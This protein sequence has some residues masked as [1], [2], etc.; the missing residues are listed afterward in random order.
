MGLQLMSSVQWLSTVQN[1]IAAGVDT[2][3]EFGP[4]RT[5]S[6]L[7]KK[8]DKSVKTLRVENCDTLEETLKEIGDR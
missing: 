7:I 2:F 8:I 4:G 3:I 1:L 6:G 5:L